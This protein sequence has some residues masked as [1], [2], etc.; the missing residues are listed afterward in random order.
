MVL[1][2]SS[3]DFGCLS[4]IRLD[5]D[6]TEI[7]DSASVA[8]YWILAAWLAVWQGRPTC[9]G[10]AIGLTRR[11]KPMVRNALLPVENPEVPE[12]VVRCLEA[13]STWTNPTTSTHVAVSRAWMR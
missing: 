2:D 10:A 4:A 9:P 5:S 12:D 11:A 8:I 3:R 6:E 7:P 1:A 13:L